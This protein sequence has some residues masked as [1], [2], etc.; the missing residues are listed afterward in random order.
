M[1][2]ALIKEAGM[3]LLRPPEP[4]PAEVHDEYDRIARRWRAALGGA[5]LGASV[6]SIIGGAFGSNSPIVQLIG[7]V[8]G[9][10]AIY[11]TIRGDG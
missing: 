5:I 4:H 11:F 6:L 8:I 1:S 9:F 3:V 7:A 10:I 2:L